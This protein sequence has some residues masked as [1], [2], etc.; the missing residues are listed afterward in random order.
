MESHGLNI[1]RLIGQGYD[2]AAPFSGKN[3]GVQRRMR[4]LSG[5]ALYIHC[6][7]RLQIASIQAA[8]SVPQIKK[9][10]GMLLYLW[11]LI[12]YS[13]QKAEKLKAAQSVL[14]LPELKVIKPSSTRWLSHECCIKA[15]C[16]ELPAIILTL[17]EL[18]ESNGDAKAFGVQSIL[19]SFEGVATVII[20]GEILNLVATFNCFM[21]RKAT[22]FSRLKVILT[23]PWTN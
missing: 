10:F 14:N 5:H 9:F 11:K 6:S 3:S 20:L 2:G 16:K 12:Y 8:D 21:Q 7:H 18:Y 22:D 4:A 23:V 19:S 17:Q 13:P 15:I 1:K